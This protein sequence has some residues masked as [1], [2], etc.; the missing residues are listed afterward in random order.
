M[1]LS[2]ARVASALLAVVLCAACGAL[3]RQAFR[4]PDVVVDAA[5]L[6]GGLQSQHF[7]LDLNIYNP[8]NYRLDASRI[9][10]R[11]LADSMEIAS[12]I[13]ER[14]VT[15]RPRDSVTVRVPVDVNERAIPALVMSFALNGGEVAWQLVG[16]M[17]I[18]TVF[19]SV[20]RPFDQRGTYNPFTRRVTIFKRKKEPSKN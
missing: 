8:N 10:Y 2:S 14:R 3:Q 1:T 13:I 9:R 11:A 7:E 16:D 20:T 17:R 15:L 12:G 19:G 6:A 18:E 4:E 5:A